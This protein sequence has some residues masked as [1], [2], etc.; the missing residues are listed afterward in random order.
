MNNNKK[1]NAEV[2]ISI[3]LGAVILVLGVAA[4]G[5]YIISDKSSSDVSEGNAI[6][7]NIVYDAAIDTPLYKKPDKSAPV[8]MQITAGTKVSFVAY[9]EKGFYLVKYNNVTGY[10]NGNHIIDS[11][12][13]T[14]QAEEQKVNMFVI[15]AQ[16]S[17]KVY[18]NA[19]VNSSILT[20]IPLGASV[21]VL[22][23]KN[24]NG[25]Y[26][27]EY[28]NQ[29]GYV[30][31]QYL[32]KDQAVAQNQQNLQNQEAAKKAQEEAE[33]QRKAALPPGSS[34]TALKQAM[35][36]TNV[37]NAIYLRTNPSDD[38]DIITTIPLHAMVYYVDT[39]GSWYKISY[40]GQ[41]GY[42]KSQYL[43]TS[44]PNIVSRSSGTRVVSG[45][46]KSI[47]LRRSPSADTSSSNVICEIPVGTVVTYLGSYGE[48]S[49]IRYNGMEGYASSQYLR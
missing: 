46:D 44:N 23:E 9:A 25:F 14:K 31:T 40:N 6:T 5:L 38:A 28:N 20:T 42:S 17:A 15:N 4:L 26:K 34:A 48:Y 35:W 49:K 16:D 2:I 32:T 21:T 7:S 8:I 13:L 22:S 47:Y 10:A 1:I 24:E 29:T 41:Y 43:T 19:D 39:C 30:E 3:I 27:A 37:Q 11:D 12:L 45:V 36:V 18:Q 33:R